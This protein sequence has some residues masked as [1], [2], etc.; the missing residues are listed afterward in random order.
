MEYHEAYT[1]YTEHDPESLYVGGER[2]SSEK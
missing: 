2:L 1:E